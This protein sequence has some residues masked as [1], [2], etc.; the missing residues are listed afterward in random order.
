M[1]PMSDEVLRQLVRLSD[2]L[3]DPARGHVILAE[4]NTSAL[5]E[6]GSFWVK[7]S[8]RALRSITAGDFVR[9]DRARVLALLE[10]GD[11]T[12]E[13]IERRLGEAR[14]DTDAEARPSVE[15]LLHAVCLGVEGVRFVAHTHPVAVNSVVCSREFEAAVDG[16]LFPDEIVVCGPSPVLVPY[17][18]PGVPLAR[19]VRRRIDAFLEVRR[20]IPRVILLQNHGLVALGATAAEAENVTEMAV[21]TARVLVGTYALGGPNFLTPRAVNRIHRR[22]DEQYRRKILG[23]ES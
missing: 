23:E 9:L 5:V 10:G 20:E 13:E 21:K 7:A 4:G 1:R 16:R 2:A 12:D 17:V 11:P 22:P 3:G 8:G 15:S 18:D 6:D 19:E 14:I